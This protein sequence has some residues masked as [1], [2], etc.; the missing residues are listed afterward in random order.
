MSEDDKVVF[1]LKDGGFFGEIAL[2]Y[3]TKRTVW[4]PCHWHCGKQP[5]SEGW[6]SRVPLQ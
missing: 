5:I 3:D 6:C 2:L 4:L 1:T